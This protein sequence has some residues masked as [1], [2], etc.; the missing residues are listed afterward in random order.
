[1][2]LR[3]GF[4]DLQWVDCKQGDRF[5]LWGL[6]GA[7]HKDWALL[8][9][10]LFVSR[11]WVLCRVSEPLPVIPKKRWINTPSDRDTRSFAAKMPLVSIGP[12]GHGE[13]GMLL[14][15]YAG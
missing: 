14:S 15:R 10:A 11:R 4:R 13:Q 7:V 6:W 9:S 3:D 1:M 5:A 2:R 12:E 8:C